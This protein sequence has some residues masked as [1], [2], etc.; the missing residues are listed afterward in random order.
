MSIITF[1]SIE[2]SITNQT[3]SLLTSAISMGINRN[4]KILVIEATYTNQS[5]TKAFFKNNESSI[6]KFVKDINGNKIDISS[7][8]HGCI[9]AVSSNK[10]TSDGVSTYATPIL[11]NG[12]LDILFGINNIS[13]REYDNCIDKLPELVHIAQNY[14]DLIYIDLEKYDLKDIPKWESEILK[15]SDLKIVSLPQDIYMID[16]FSKMWGHEEPLLLKPRVIPLLTKEDKDSKY[17]CDNVAREISARPGMPSIIYNTL[18]MESLQEGTLAN[19]MY[20]LIT[21]SKTDNQTQA[22]LDAIDDL[23]LLIYDRLQQLINYK[24]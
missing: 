14:Y 24:K 16:K 5:M 18:L 22:F 13:K 20:T 8:L 10:L 2:N 17:N 3:S 19:Y 11:E 6:K 23:N 7:G 1:F 12:R 15:M 4:V 9:S 21:N